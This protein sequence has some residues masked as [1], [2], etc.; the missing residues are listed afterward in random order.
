MFRKALAALAV[1][2]IIGAGPSLAQA[3]EQPGAVR[4]TPA[5]TEDLATY[6]AA[7]KALEGQGYAGLT[8]SLP[9]LRAALDRAPDTYPVFDLRDDVMIVRSPDLADLLMASATLTAIKERGEK[10]PD[11]VVQQPNVYP[12]IALLLGS[13]AIERGLY[14]KGIDYLDRG[15]RLQP[16][17]WVLITEKAAALQGQRRWTDAL[18]LVDDALARGDMSIEMNAAPLH[19]RRGFSLIELGRLTEAKAAYEASLKLEPDSENAKGELEYISKLESGQALPTEVELVS[20]LSK[21]P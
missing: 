8:P 12:E 3:A 14:Q 15:L 11:S 16:N 9:A 7:M 20:P 13:E 18:A 4:L 17:H 6:Q 2:M 5:E 19:R 10:A 1:L 21:E